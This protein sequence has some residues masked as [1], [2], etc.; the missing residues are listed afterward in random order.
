MWL[1]PTDSAH[2]ADLFWTNPTCAAEAPKRIGP[3]ADARNAKFS[4]GQ[5]HPVAPRGSA[6]QQRKAKGATASAP[7]LTFKGGI[8]WSKI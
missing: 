1:P 8:S 4:S 7:L 2:V 6:A 3:G 5:L